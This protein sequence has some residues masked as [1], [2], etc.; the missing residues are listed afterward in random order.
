MYLYLFLVNHYPQLMVK[1]D[2]PTGVWHGGHKQSSIVIVC[3][4]YIIGASRVHDIDSVCFRCNDVGIYV[5]SIPVC[6]VSPI[7]SP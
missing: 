6:E 2:T 7:E 4:S 3:T 5:Y 1:D